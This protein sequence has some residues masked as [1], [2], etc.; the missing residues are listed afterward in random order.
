M[1]GR[2]LNPY[3]RSLTAGGSSGGE[4]ALIGNIERLLRV[5]LSLTIYRSTQRQSTRYG[6]VLSYIDIV[7]YFDFIGVASDIGA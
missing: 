7:T 3:N 6:N 1:F 5:R 2:T 4:G